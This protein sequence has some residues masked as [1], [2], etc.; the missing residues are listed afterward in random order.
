M[1]HINILSVVFLTVNNTQTIQSFKKRYR[2]K[3]RMGFLAVEANVRITFLDVGRIYSFHALPERDSKSRR[4]PQEILAR[5]YLLIEHIK[6][7]SQYLPLGPFLE[8][9]VAG[10]NDAPTLY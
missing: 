10:A 1:I 6:G 9:N 8:V 3:P 5:P 4:S 2:N 7:A